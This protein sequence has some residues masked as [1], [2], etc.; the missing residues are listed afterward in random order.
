MLLEELPDVVACVVAGRRQRRLLPLGGAERQRQFLGA[1]RPGTGSRPRRL[2]GGLGDENPGALLLQLGLGLSED[3]NDPHFRWDDLGLL[4]KFADKRPDPAL[5]QRAELAEPAAGDGRGPARPL[6]RRS[7]AEVDART[8][9]CDERRSS[10]RRWTWN[11]CRGT[12]ATARTSCCRSGT[13]ARWAGATRRS[14]RSGCARRPPGARAHDTARAGPAVARLR[15]RIR[16]RARDGTPLLRR[17]HPQARRQG[18]FLGRPRS[19][20]ST[21]WRGSRSPSSACGGCGAPTWSSPRRPWLRFGT[22][23]RPDDKGDGGGTARTPASGA[24]ERP[25]RE[26]PRAARAAGGAA[27]G[28][29]A[30]AAAGH[31]LLRLEP[32]GRRA[33]EPAC[34][35]D[36]PAEA[37]VEPRRLRRAAVGAVRRRPGAGPRGAAR[38]GGAGEGREGGRGRRE[39]RGRGAGNVGVSFGAGDGDNDDLSSSDGE[40]V[41]HRELEVRGDAGRDDGGTGAFGQDMLDSLPPVLE[42]ARGTGRSSRCARRRSCTQGE[43]RRGLL[44]TLGARLAAA[45]DVGEAP[46]E[47]QYALKDLDIDFPSQWAAVDFVDG[48]EW[49]LHQESGEL[50]KYLHTRPFET[51]TLYRAGGTR[52]RPSRRCARWATSRP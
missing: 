14:A 35:V 24:A 10:T 49:W 2:R 23:P 6:R 12:R 25:R 37:P 19:R 44:E 1:R 11:S 18:K 21:A 9:E 4:E 52:T 51:Y 28:P 47:P 29:R 34:A 38:A 43:E 48:R 42:D 13:G 41:V 33:R 39:R 50:E 17:A 36:L 31:P 20:R 16:P 8:P 26:L 45:A 27:R 5:L 22:C 15:G 3:A 32:R 40:S 30:G 7:V 46:G